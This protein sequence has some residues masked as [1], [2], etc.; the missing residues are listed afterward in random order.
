MLGR[1]E[2]RY[3]SLILLLINSIAKKGIT[4][5]CALISFV[6]KKARCSRS[7]RYPSEAATRDPFD[8]FNVFKY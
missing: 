1:L 7:L 3:I 5:G 4:A 6:R 2:S 8:H